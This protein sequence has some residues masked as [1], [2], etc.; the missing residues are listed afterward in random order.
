MAESKRLFQRIRNAIP[1]GIFKHPESVNEAALDIYLTA[2]GV[3]P[4]CIPFDGEVR[5]GGMS[6]NEMIQYIQ[7]HPNILQKL[8]L[9]R[10]LTVLIGPYY[11]TGT[12]IVIAN[13]N[14]YKSGEVGVLLKQL[15]GIAKRHGNVRGHAPKIHFYIGT[16]L[17]YTCPM[18]MQKLY[19][20][21][22]LYSIAFM[23]DGRDHMG[24]W[25]PIEQQYLTKALKQLE[26][27]NEA[28]KPIDKEATL[29]IGF[30]YF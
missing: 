23:I 21:K 1:A 28:L 8:S 6:S 3:R 29:Q 5:Y 16:L 17:G 7:E 12:S 18:S 20:M 19:S 26:S 25:C 4:A 14:S 15:D 10:E 24:V 11:D 13:T 2:K 27:M 30:Q 22:K 9:I